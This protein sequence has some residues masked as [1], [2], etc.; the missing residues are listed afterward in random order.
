MG[1]SR[2]A[3]LGIVQEGCLGQADPAP[4]LAQLQVGPVHDAPHPVRHDRGHHDPTQAVGHGTRQPGARSHHHDRRASGH[5]IPAW[6]LRVI[7]KRVTHHPESPAHPW[8]YV[9]K[10]AFIYK[11]TGMWTTGPRPKR[12]SRPRRGSGSC[13]AIQP[14]MPG[15]GIEPARMEYHPPQSK[16]G[17]S[18]TPQRG[19]Y[20]APSAGLM[21]K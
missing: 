8:R 2:R 14:E 17:V 1:T 4:D 9:A 19:R 7:H 11:T 13:T 21:G 5:Q 12:P 3:E 20:E 10:A 15:T 16:C 6:M 18:A